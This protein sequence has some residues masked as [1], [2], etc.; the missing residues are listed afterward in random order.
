MLI[1]QKLDLPEP[2]VFITSDRVTF[3]KPHPEPFESGRIALLAKM[4][5]DQATTVVF[6]D[7]PAGIRSG[8]AAGCIVIA[9]CTSHTRQQLIDS[10]SEPDFIVND[11]N[12]VDLVVKNSKL[13]FTVHSDL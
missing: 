4:T 12:S 8:K 3:G 13:H 2:E 10:G 7:A 6:E 11:L 9:V 1:F 5:V